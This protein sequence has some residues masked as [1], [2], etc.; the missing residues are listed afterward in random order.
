MIYISTYSLLLF[1]T[2]LIYWF[3]KKTFDL[4]FLILTVWTISS[5]FSV[6]CFI[7]Q[8]VTIRYSVELAPLLFLYLSLIYSFSPILKL[9]DNTI[10]KLSGN[11]RFIYILSLF[12]I[13]ISIIPFFENLIHLLKNYSSSNFNENIVQINDLRR[14]GSVLS[15]MSSV[16]RICNNI[17]IILFILSPL[18][19]FYWIPRKNVSIIFKLLLLLPILQNLLYG[20]NS[21]SR[22]YLNGVIIIVMVAFIL[23][24]KTLP[25]KLARNVI[26]T[27]MIVGTLFIISFIYITVVR[28]NLSMKDTHADFTMLDFISIYAGESAIRFND[29]WNSHALMNGDNTLPFFKYILGF[30]SLTSN[31]QIYEYWEKQTGISGNLFYTFVG[32]F[33]GDFGPFGSLIIITLFII[34]LFRCYPKNG[35]ISLYK[36]YYILIWSYICLFGFTYYPFKTWFGGLILFVNVLV[37]VILKISNIKQKY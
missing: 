21:S 30:D 26:K 9:K 2:L 7:E 35:I 20:F 29:M 28:F 15:W 33:V 22:A 23:L 32:D 25:N 14:V 31:I 1:L 16:G 10:L 36:I 12:V 4:G 37:L 8:N 24:R 17:S 18:L 13:G 27:G 19:L 6:Y 3:K 11:K 5:F 34:P